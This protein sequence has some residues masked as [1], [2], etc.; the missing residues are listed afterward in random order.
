MLPYNEIE[1]AISESKSKKVDVILHAH[2]D[3][4]IKFINR[5]NFF[6]VIVYNGPYTKSFIKDID[7]ETI[8]E[9]RTLHRQIVDT[10]NGLGGDVIRWERDYRPK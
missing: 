9:C 8:K 6:E 4:D 10:I 1:K 2:Y 7:I 5:G 3:K